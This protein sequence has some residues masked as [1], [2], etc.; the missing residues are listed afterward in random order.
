[1]ASP[2]KIQNYKEMKNLI[3]I[4]SDCEKE[5]KGEDV[6]S[7]TEEEEDNKTVESTEEDGEKYYE[8]LY[9]E[10]EFFTQ[11][12]LLEVKKMLLHKKPDN[13]WRDFK[14][15]PG[16]SYPKI[17][18]VLKRRGISESI[19]RRKSQQSEEEI[20][21]NGEVFIQCDAAYYE[22]LKEF[23][24]A[25]LGCPGNCSEDDDTHEICQ[26]CDCCIDSPNMDRGRI[27]WY[28][29]VSGKKQKY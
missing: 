24:M 17:C 23:L 3:V 26:G 21:D 2:A 9:Y 4:D 20:E 15:C 10:F 5:E 1:M 16:W 27:E 13:V 22:K 7:T 12:L 28:V 6:D 8:E 29:S 19:I 25:E 11:Q 14:N 18:R